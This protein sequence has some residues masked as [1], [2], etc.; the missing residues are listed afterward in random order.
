MRLYLA[1]VPTGAGEYH[2]RRRRTFKEDIPHAPSPRRTSF[3]CTVLVPPQRGIVYIE[4]CNDNRVD[5]VFGGR[6]IVIGML[7]PVVGEVY[8]DVC[9]VYE[10]KIKVGIGLRMGRV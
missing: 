2:R 10:A 7:E 3:L 5:R 4:L 6:D 1:P 8:I 9:R